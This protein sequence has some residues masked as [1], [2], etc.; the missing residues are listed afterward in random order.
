[1]LPEVWLLPTEI[2]EPPEKSSVLEHELEI[3]ASP[4]YVTGTSV[5]PF[6][7]A[8]SVT[9]NVTAFPF[10]ELPSDTEVGLADNVMVSPD[11]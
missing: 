10:P 8:L 5:L 9:V 2:V 1:M 6:D 11:A 4:P 3:C 7:L